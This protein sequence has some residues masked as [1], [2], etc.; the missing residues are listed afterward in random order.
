MNVGRLAARFL[1]AVLA[2]RAIS[3][4]PGVV[5]VL[6]TP[7]VH[8]PGTLVGEVLANTVLPLGLSALCWWGAPTVSDRLLAPGAQAGVWPTSALEVTVFRAVGLYLTLAAVVG[9][10]LWIP[11]LFGSHYGGFAMGLFIESLAEL[12]AGLAVLGWAPSLAHWLDRR[13]H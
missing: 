11:T 3:T 2:V 12:A 4:L 5:T 10:V 7:D 8:V 9:V 13:R 6:L 1:A